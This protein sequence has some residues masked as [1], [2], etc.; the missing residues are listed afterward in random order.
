MN[1]ELDVVSEQLLHQLNDIISKIQTQ[2]RTLE[3]EIKNFQH[4]HDIYYDI[5]YAR[6]SNRSSMNP[7]IKIKKELKAI[8][9]YLMITLKQMHDRQRKILSYIYNEQM[10]EELKHPLITTPLKSKL[11]TYFSRTTLFIQRIEILFE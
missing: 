7:S 10:T 11:K 9:G 2:E 6:V 1:Q 4:L 8:Y 3:N 5:R